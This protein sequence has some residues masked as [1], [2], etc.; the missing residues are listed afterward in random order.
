MADI[1]K[2]QFDLLA[3]QAALRLENGVQKVDFRLEYFGSDSEPLLD[4]WTVDASLLQEG[5]TGSLS[6]QLTAVASGEATPPPA[7]GSVPISSRLSAIGSR[8]AK[9]LVELRVPPHLPVWLHLAKP[10]GWLGTLPWEAALEEQTGK[11][12]LRLPDFLERPRENV[13]SLDVVVCSDLAEDPSIV[14]QL[15]RVINA[16]LNGSPRTQT[17]VMVFALP[18]NSRALR[19]KFKSDSRVWI[20]PSPSPASDS[21]FVY[22]SRR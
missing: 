14:E 19:N 16:I 17:H 20:A 18:E 12:V 15:E 8:V 11:P 1:L 5:S 7:A 13:V 10:Y 6:S 22:W 2:R 4:A 9:T 3:L 21:D